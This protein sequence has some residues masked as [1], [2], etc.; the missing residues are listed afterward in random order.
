[1]F[2]QTLRKQMNMNTNELP[3]LKF[4]RKRSRVKT[5]P[6]GKSNRDGK[7][8][9]YVDH[10]DKGYCH[11]CD[12]TFLPDVEKHVFPFSPP[13][14]LK[15]ET[16]PSY[17]KP[18]T[19]KAS[20]RGYDTNVFVQFLNERFGEERASQ[21]VS[22]YFIG[23]TKKGGTVFW[24]IDTA[25]R[26]RSGKVI[27]YDPT[28]H[29]L[30]DVSPS[31]VH[32]ELNLK[33]YKLKQCLFGEHLLKGNYKPAAIVESEKT[34]AIAS[35]YFPDFLW[36]ACGGINGLTNEKLIAFKGRKIILFPDVQGFNLWSQRAK[37]LAPMLEIK[38]S[39]LLERKATETERA[40]KLDIADYLLRFEIE[41]FVKPTEPYYDTLQDGTQILMSP[42]GYPM[43]WDIPTKP[44]TDLERMASKHPNLKLLIER[45]DLIQLN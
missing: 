36:L 3:P 27:Q 16:A 6:C 4:D 41:D 40:G 30:K 20:L 26:I 31:W 8:T 45:L 32:T 24:Q 23:S 22:K 7:F 15:T 14:R 37:E 21:V 34:A 9:P 33:D 25:G 2:N 17:I 42:K 11:A 10:D 18:E 35:L 29:R 39:D 13:K 28:G 19:L 12:K 1:M 5:C 44:I 43:D 38:V